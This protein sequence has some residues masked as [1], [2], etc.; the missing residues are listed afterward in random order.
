MEKNTRSPD[1][2]ERG[3]ARVAHERQGYNPFSGARETIGSYRL[4]LVFAFA[5][6]RV[7]NLFLMTSFLR[8]QTPGNMLSVGSSRQTTRRDISLIVRLSRLFS[9][10]RPIRF[11]VCQL[12]QL[13]L[14]AGLLKIV[15]PRTDAVTDA[16][17]HTV[18]HL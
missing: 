6:G 16:R 18:T 2:S 12:P 4:F 7:P 14:S 11:V 13:V 3:Y 9:F 17:L 10:S 15:F 1:H 8:Y 5:S